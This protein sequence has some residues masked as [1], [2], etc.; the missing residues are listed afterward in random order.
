MKPR[1]RGAGTIM[2]E[3]P[4]KQPTQGRR[5]TQE[6]PPAEERGIYVTLTAAVQVLVGVGLVFFLIRR[7]WENVFLTVVVVLLTLVPT[8]VWRRYRVVVP[9]EFQFVSALFVFLSL[10]LG[11]AANLYYRYWW[12]DIVL[13]T[14]SG[15]LLGIIGFLA[16]FVLN[17]T[18][19]IPRGITPF[20][21][22]FF[23]VTFAVFLG[24]V[25]EIFEFL[26]D[27]VW[28]ATN[29]Q[30]LETG[31]VD[32]MVDLIVD[33]L[34]AVIVAAMGWVYLRTGRY[35]FIADGVRKFVDRNPRLFKHR[36]T[37]G[38]E[39]KAE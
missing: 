2:D 4:Q 12:W 30:S 25:W 39:R 13:H 23:A 6:Q 31:I 21:L 7:D 1:A 24:V 9:P 11:S 38:G 20:F 35:S 3:A 14:S 5:R 29:M 8:F 28:P 17:Q 32:T 18:D 34:G 36:F 10:F 22:C 27:R 19:R 33:L 15:F 37:R 16:V 26:I